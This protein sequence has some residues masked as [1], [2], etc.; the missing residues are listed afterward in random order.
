ML[1]V[2]TGSGSVWPHGQARP[3]PEKSR[4]PPVQP[5]RASVE[6]AEGAPPSQLD[7]HTESELLH[8]VT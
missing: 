3:N 2:S 5:T 8:N 1:H 4:Y 7:T 6:P